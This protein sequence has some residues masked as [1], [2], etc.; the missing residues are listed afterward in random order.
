MVTDCERILQAADPLLGYAYEREFPLNTNIK[1]L[2]ECAKTKLSEKEI[3]LAQV[4][5][6]RNNAIA[7]VRRHTQ[8]EAALG[9][10]EASLSVKTTAEGT[11][12][13]VE[14]TSLQSSSTSQPQVADVTEKSLSGSASK[15]LNISFSPTLEQRTLDEL[16]EKF[17]KFNK[18]IEEK[19]YSDDKKFT[20]LHKLIDSRIKEYQAKVAAS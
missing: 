4:T 1:N 8:R 18:A 13:K 7:E 10:L 2:V 19:S 20:T 3:A 12:C 11:S 6:D 14:S 17:G 15:T 5:A 16:I 9:Q